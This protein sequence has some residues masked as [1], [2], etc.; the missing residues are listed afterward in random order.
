MDVSLWL[1]VCDCPF[2]FA[3]VVVCLWLCAAVARC[4]CVGVDQTNMYAPVN[5]LIENHCAQERAPP[6]MV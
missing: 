5:N 2:V 3:F 1:C 6:V 4:G